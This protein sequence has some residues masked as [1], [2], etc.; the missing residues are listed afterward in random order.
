MNDYDI[1][2]DYTNNRLTTTHLTPL[3]D[4][5][6]RQTQV[7]EMSDK[8]QTTYDGARRP[9]FFHRDIAPAGESEITRHYDGDGREVK[10]EERNYVETSPDV[11]QWV[12]EPGELLLGEYN[13]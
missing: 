5:D 10:R 2:H 8:L 6:G 11:W 9:T 1:D 13:L 12:N 4:A 3:Y 7:K